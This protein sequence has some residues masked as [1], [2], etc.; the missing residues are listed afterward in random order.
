MAGQLLGLLTTGE[1]RPGLT[2]LEGRK[3]AGQMIEALSPFPVG[4]FTWQ[5]LLPVLPLVLPLLS[6]PL[7]ITLPE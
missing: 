1:L 2:Q 3:V 6:W 7:P 4:G 5:R